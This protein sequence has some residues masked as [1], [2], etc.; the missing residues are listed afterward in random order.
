MG[1]VLCMQA[2]LIYY[3]YKKLC[4]YFYRVGGPCFIQCLYKGGALRLRNFIVYRLPYLT[5]GNAGSSIISEDIEALRSRRLFIVRL[6]AYYK[7]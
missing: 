3:R 1:A 5:Y 2:V 7:Q 6:A 4:S